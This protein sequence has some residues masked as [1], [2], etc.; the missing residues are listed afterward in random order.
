MAT[1]PFQ[2][3]ALTVP[4]KDIDSI[5]A[6]LTD[7]IGLLQQH[8]MSGATSKVAKAADLAAL[9]SKADLGS[10]LPL[11]GGTMTGLLLLS[12]DPTAAL[13]AVPRRKL[14]WEP[15]D[16]Q[17]LSSVASKTITL[18]DYAGYTDF[19]DLLFR[20]DLLL[21]AADDKDLYMQ[22]NGDA[23]SNYLVDTFIWSSAGSVNQSRAAATQ[24]AI[25]NTSGGASLYTGKP[26]F[27]AIELKQFQDTAYLKRIKFEMAHDSNA[28]T[29]QQF[30]GSGTW[31][32]AGTPAVTSATFSME[33]GGNFSCIL[34]VSGRRN[35][36]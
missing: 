36:T 15:L 27:V 14:E 16:V 28:F 33:S 26:A 19:A 35:H 8:A 31:N 7:V 12:G 2:G 11:A 18:S 29:N 20:L 32:K 23:G 6:A 10:Y 24:F 22:L 25:G 1:S 9:P 21:T 17:T 5:H 30:K 34:S 13:D 3:N 4:S